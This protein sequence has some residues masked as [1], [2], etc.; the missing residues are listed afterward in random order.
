MEAVTRAHIPGVDPELR[1]INT[2]PTRVLQM[3]FSG[4]QPPAAKAAAK[5]ARIANKKLNR[6]PLDPRGL[7]F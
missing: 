5:T 1:C 7:D 3:D 2:E 4:P 6:E